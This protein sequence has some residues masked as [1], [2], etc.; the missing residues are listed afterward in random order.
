MNSAR[1]LIVNAD[2]FGQSPAINRGII[3]AHQKGILT[4][5]SMMVRWMAA[6]QAAALARD[7]PRLS[8]GLHV[9]LGE[10]KCQDGDWHAVYEVTNL[11]DEQQVREEVARQL[12][13]FQQ[14]IGIKPSH[15]DS[16]Q[17]V[18]RREPTRSVLIDLAK[19]LSVPLREHDPRVEYCGRFYGE[20]ADGSPLTSFVSCGALIAIL[21]ELPAGVTELGCH[22]ASAVD[23]DS[24]YA[25]PRIEELR[26][27]TSPEARDAV[28][29]LAIELCSFRDVTAAARPSNSR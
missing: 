12:E 16:H 6:Q 2:D 24:M 14:L 20:S 11:Q 21:R 18:H 7:N 9:D 1:K 22:P 3:D 15:I 28:A 13:Q 17:H 25:A 10:W 26:T 4:S 23:F 29:A 8:L 19:S 5:A 27:L